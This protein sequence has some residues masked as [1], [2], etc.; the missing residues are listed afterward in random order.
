MYHTLGVME[1]KPKCLAVLY[2]YQTCRTKLSPKKVKVKVTQLC[3]ALWDTMDC[4]PPSSSVHR[5]SRQEYWSGQWFPSPG[6]LPK[7][8]IEPR[9]P[10]LQADSSPA[11]PQ[12]NP[13]NTGVG[14][15]SL[16][17]RIFP[18]Q[19]LNQGLLHCRWILYQLSYQGALFCR[20]KPLCNLQYRFTLVN[21]FI[22]PDPLLYVNEFLNP[23]YSFS[24][25]AFI[26]CMTMVA[27]FIIQYI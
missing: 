18:T 10:A 5:I 24:P 15:G 3:P 4:S 17:Q 8:G 27:K 1:C 12:V 13:Q 26:S 22:S 14:S 25:L 9:S 11:E 7:P 16:L 2:L 19:E 6:D 20:S 23:V 21:S